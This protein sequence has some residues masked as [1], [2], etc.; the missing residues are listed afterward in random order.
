MDTTRAPNHLMLFGL[1]DVGRFAWD[2]L[3]DLSR[4]IVGIS[5][6]MS[7]CN[8]SDIS[9]KF[10]VRTFATMGAQKKIEP[11]RKENHQHLW[12]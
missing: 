10:I 4:I 8:N 6:T 2:F 5:K 12:T 11:T 9:L 1:V 7:S 3:V